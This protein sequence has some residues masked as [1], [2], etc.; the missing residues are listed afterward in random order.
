MTTVS[1]RTIR[2]TV[3][4]QGESLQ[5]LGPALADIYGLLRAHEGQ[6]AQAQAWRSLTLWQRLR[7]LVTGQYGEA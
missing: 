1:L 2:K 3:Q 5:A 6:I 7:W 4:T